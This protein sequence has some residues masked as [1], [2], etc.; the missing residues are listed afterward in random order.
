MASDDTLSA[1]P[2]LVELEELVDEEAGDDRVSM[3]GQAPVPGVAAPAQLKTAE[4]GKN[5]AASDNK[6]HPLDARQ[7]SFGKLVH[8][9]EDL[10]ALSSTLRHSQ[11]N[12]SP[13]YLDGRIFAEV[14]FYHIF[15]PL[16]VPIML[17]R[18]G[19]ESS[20]KMML[21]P[22]R[23]SLP[24][25]FFNSIMHLA[26]F[27]L[28]IYGGF[29]YFTGSDRAVTMGEVSVC[30]LIHCLR[31]VVIATK[32]GY[33]TRRDRHQFFNVRTLMPALF[34]RDLQII[35]GWMVP[36]AHLIRTHLEDAAA[37]QGVDMI[38]TYLRVVNAQENESE[39]ALALAPPLPGQDSRVLNNSSLCALTL[40]LQFALEAR[41]VG[42]VKTP[43]GFAIGTLL[44]IIPHVFRLVRDPE[45]YAEAEYHAY[46]SYVFMFLLFTVSFGS[47]ALFLAVAVADTMRRHVFMRDLSDII[48]REGYRPGGFNESSDGN[49]REHANARLILDMRDPS[50][51]LNWL[52]CRRV[53]RD[54]GRPFFCRISAYTSYYFVTIL[55]LSA[56]LVIALFAPNI[57]V[58]QD[59]DSSQDIMIGMITFMII[60][61]II[62]VG[63]I[64]IIG[65]RMNR[66]SFR[67]RDLLLK[68]QTVVRQLLA[69]ARRTEHLD[70]QAKL[71]RAMGVSADVATAVARESGPAKEQMRTTHTG[72]PFCERG[73]DLSE[74]AIERGY[75]D[76]HAKD[77][78]GFSA[79]DSSIC[80]SDGRLLHQ[81]KI[82]RILSSSKATYT[83]HTLK[84]ADDLLTVVLA[85]VELDAQANPASLMGIE[86]GG[87]IVKGLLTVVMAG[88]AA[89]LR[90][91]AL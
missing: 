20:A 1:L 47:T 55:I 91:L 6:I 52:A 19:T 18:L 83:S 66:V 10:A 60:L 46:I 5:A 72:D 76:D 49:V 32:Y 36:K 73:K 29:I 75:T 11:G 15:H 70:E 7:E 67:H 13:V 64:A 90:S 4:D 53:L 87:P 62:P 26:V 8:P 22:T 57:N 54:F 27:W 65:G 42:I 86:A 45:V 59:N 12:S 9:L 89:G 23:R 34:Q 44:A 74:V 43:L 80:N 85:E 35:S 21:W 88:V 50:T 63:C 41:H 30:L 48:D 69:E 14:L 77:A 78:P 39:H 38:A 40:W 33:M 81:Y 82:G 51:V 16:S 61:F 68:H 79:H 24:S 17:W 3:V 71:L 2:R 37:R 84:L 31:A 25:F 56:Y 58:G 28:A